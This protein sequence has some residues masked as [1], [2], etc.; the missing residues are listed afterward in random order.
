MARS[1]RC[2]WL[3]LKPH[4]AKSPPFGELLPGCRDDVFRKKAELFL[5][6]FQRRRCPERLHADASAVAAYIPRPAESRRLFHRDARRDRIRQDLLAILRM[7]A[8]VML[9]DLPRWHAHYPSLDPLG[10]EAAH[11]PRHTARPRCRWRATGHR[12]GRSRH[13]RA[14]TRRV[15]RPP[16]GRILYGPAPAAPAASE[17]M[18]PAR[19]GTP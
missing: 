11:T 9:E 12:G 17:S 19:G 7:I 1:A 13:P 3:A 18:S 2:H 10:L 4:Y 16:P 8:A 5:Q 14:H 6:F 15:A